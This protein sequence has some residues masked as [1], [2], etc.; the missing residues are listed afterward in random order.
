LFEQLL[1]DELGLQLPEFEEQF[2]KHIQ[3]IR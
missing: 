1:R 3:S 2:V